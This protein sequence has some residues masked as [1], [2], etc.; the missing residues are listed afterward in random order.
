M[1]YMCCQ[2]VTAAHRVYHLKNDILGC[3]LEVYIDHKM[4][5]DTLDPPLKTT[6]DIYEHILNYGKGRWAFEV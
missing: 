1:C 2:V 5:A 6:H 3:I 4:K